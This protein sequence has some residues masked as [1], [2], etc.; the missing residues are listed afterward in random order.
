MM[1]LH[2]L[3]LVFAA[4]VGIGV[5]DVAAQTHPRF[6]VVSIK[7]LDRTKMRGGHEGFLLNTETFI[8]RTELLQYIVQAYLGGSSCV[9]RVT[10]E[11]NGY[12]RDG[13]CPQL[14]GTMPA[15]IKTDRWEI[16]AKLPPGVPNYS[17][18]R[19]R[20][21][22][23]PEINLMLQTLLAER[24]GLQVHWEK[25][26]VPVFALTL[27]KGPLKLRKSS[28]TSGGGSVQTVPVQDGS[29][30]TTLNMAATS[31]QEAADTFSWYFDRLVVDRT[32][33][34]GDYDWSIEY[35]EDPDA[36]IPGNPFSGLTTSAL[37]KALQSVGLRLESTKAPI[38]VLVIDHVEKPSEN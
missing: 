32:G 35:E 36:R 22:D 23:T 33:L 2:G 29:R 37:S 5:L 16:I 28:E 4:T 31:P 7:P 18:K 8:D 1:R 6:E 24:F 11:I 25:R 20:F 14:A 30:R 9:M 12:S 19:K 27:G 13:A 21:R 17:A 15:W 26:E 3:A 38:Q 34:K 10:F